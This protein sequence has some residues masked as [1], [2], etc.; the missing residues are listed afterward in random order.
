MSPA[1]NHQETLV[2]IGQCWT[3]Q[4]HQGFP[5]QFSPFTMTNT[6]CC[7]IAPEAQQ[8]ICTHTCETPTVEVGGLLLGEV[9]QQGKHHLVRVTHALPAQH[10][11]AGAIAV[12]F[13]SNTWL[14]LI[15]SRARY[16]DNMTV[17]WY[18]SH[19]GMGV[20]LSG[21]DLFTHRSFFA[22]K[23]WYLALVIDPQFGEQGVFVWEKNKVVS[24]PLLSLFEPG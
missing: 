8:V 2:T 15:A 17:G 19:P 10:T 12:T 22:D 1:L 14:D 5:H 13:T 24:A 21:Q 11:E 23:P 3:K 18:H 20:F 16:P 6:V 4:P 9:Y 7:H